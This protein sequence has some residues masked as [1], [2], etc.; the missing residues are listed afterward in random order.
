LRKLIVNADDYGL[1]PEVS[2]GIRLATSGIVRSTTVLANLVTPSDLA[3]LRESRL[4]AG[5]H[6]N[7]SLGLPLAAGYPAHLLDRQRRFSKEAALSNTT[8]DD[9]GL[10]G[11]VATEWRAQIEILVGRGLTLTH[12]DSHH[13][14]H[15]F[16]PLF[17]VAAALATEYRLGL[18]TDQSNLPIAAASGVKRPSLLITDFYGAGKLA[19]ENLL[20]LLAQS[21]RQDSV[22]LMC[23][24]GLATDELRA[25]SGYT[26]ERESEL[27]VLGD[28]ALALKLDEQGWMLCGYGDL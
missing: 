26:D 7:L 22:E 10:Q 19:K 23:H 17:E 8:W 3:E 14:V 20:A 16:A 9:A 24:P 6:L 28:P 4:Q 11:A 18:R 21:E 5:V 25:I 12:L 13:H 15:L 2:Q 1:T 27:A